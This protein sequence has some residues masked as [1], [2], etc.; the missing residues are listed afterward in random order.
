MLGTSCY[1]G[2]LATVSYTLAGNHTEFTPA[3][4]LAGQVSVSPMMVACR[5]VFLRLVVLFLEDNVEIGANTTIDRGALEDTIISQGTMI[6]NLVQLGHNV[7]VG[8]SCVIVSQVGISGSTKVEDYVQL[9]GQ[10][11]IAGHLTIGKGA[12]IAA[13]SG[14][15]RM[16]KR[17]LRVMRC[18][19]HSDP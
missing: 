15:M 4:A 1:V 14:I 3:H 12:K 13:Q 10:V 7:Q 8:K 5:F 19:S 17:A 11:G 2:A 16:L 18:T 9:G 6:D